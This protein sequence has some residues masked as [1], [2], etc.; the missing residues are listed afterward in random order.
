VTFH[1]DFPRTI[2]DVSADWLSAQLGGSSSALAGFDAEPIAAGVGIIGRL[3][4]L[5]LRWAEPGTGPESVVVKVATGTP[6]TKNLVTLFNFYGK[7]VGFYREL[8]ARTGTRTP[9]C[10]AAHF[11]PDTQEFILVLED[12]GAGCLVDQ[13][14]GCTSEQV[15]TVVDELAALHASWWQHPDLDG[16]TWLQ[17][18]SDPLYTIGIPIGLD[19][20]WAAATTILGDTIPDWFLARWDDF[21]AGVPSL[22][23]RLDALPLTLCHGDT[24][25]DNLLFGV[26]ADPVMFLDWQIVLHAPGIYDLGYFM[27]QSVPVKLRRAIESDTV[28]RYRQQ[29]VDRGVPAPP[30]DQLWEG[31]RLISLY[32]VVY[33]LIGSGPAD[34]SN[35]RA[36]RLVRT[37]AERGF[38]AIDDLDALEL[39]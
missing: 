10:Y 29:L 19:Q 3:S 1:S 17:R 33:P 38:A 16:I 15:A 2:E 24:R 31:Y 22:L 14:E 7:E 25:L 20:T 36:M 34:P 9:D 37:I 27:S 11:D 4:R 26:G 32:C 18:L 28:A 8:A 23:G 35:E 21:R 39:L 6:A 13:I 5:R 30:P 12:G